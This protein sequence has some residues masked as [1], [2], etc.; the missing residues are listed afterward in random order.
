MKCPTSSQTVNR[1]SIYCLQGLHR[2]HCRKSYEEFLCFPIQKPTFNSDS[3]FKSIFLEKSKV[4]E[5]LKTTPKFPIKH[6][7]K[8]KQ[9]ENKFNTS[10]SREKFS[11][12]KQYYSTSFELYNNKNTLRIY[13]THLIKAD[14]RFAEI[15]DFHLIRSFIAQYFPQCLDLI[16][17]IL[18]FAGFFHY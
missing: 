18:F 10:L 7:D 16:S 6:F 14:E 9:I 5:E 12:F 15:A 1:T 2:N 3:K 17:W 13:R 4:P 11:K 8:V